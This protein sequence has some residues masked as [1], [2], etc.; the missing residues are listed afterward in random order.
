MIAVEVPAE[1]LDA[2]MPPWAQQISLLSLLILI[3]LAFLRGWIVTKLQNERDVDAERRVSD[4][5]EANANQ[6]TELNKELTQAFAP[7][8]EQ[9]EAILKAVLAVQEEQRRMREQ[10]G[11]RR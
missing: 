1:G 2:L 5:W 7:V 8:L 3:V 9:N 11:P 10:R 6:S 4:I